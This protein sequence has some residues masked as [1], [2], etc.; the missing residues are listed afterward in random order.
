MASRIQRVEKVLLVDDHEYVVRS[1]ARECRKLQRVPLVSVDG[2]GAVETAVSERPE[3]AIIDLF[4]PRATGIELIRE[5]RAAGS[6]CFIV[7]VSAAMSW[8][9]VMQAVHAGAND[10][11]DKTVQV[12]R[13]I[14]QIEEGSQP[15]PELGK[16]PSLDEVEWQYISRVLDECGGNVTHAAEILKIHRYSLQRK[17][18]K[19][20]PSTFPRAKHA[21]RVRVETRTSLPL[22]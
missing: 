11:C 4:M 10:C 2:V 9:F 22:G 5:L 18:K 13:Y 1:W 19:Q 7:L 8:R 3:L 14:R 15:Q 17:L 12:A 16:F 6:D 20:S 21:R